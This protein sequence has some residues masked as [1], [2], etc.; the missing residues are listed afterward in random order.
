MGRRSGG[1]EIIA[2]HIPKAAGESFRAV[3]E[4]VYGEDDVE[5]DLNDQVPDDAG[6]LHR[7]F[8]AWN[9]ETR[10]A[11]ERRTSWR[12]VVT[13]HFP[14]WKYER[15]RGSAF[16]IVWLREPVAR[17]ISM[18]FYLRQKPRRD[19]GALAR[20][21]TPVERLMEVEWPSNPYTERFLR[22][23]DL[24][25]V[26]FVGIQEH[27]AEDVAD[28][29]GMLGWPPVDIPVSNRTTTPEYLSFR[30]SEELVRRIRAVNQ[31]DIELYE[32]ALELR[33]ARRLAAPAQ[34][35]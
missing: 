22:G 8:D 25:D 31:A 2:V 14:L 12:K 33:R 29:G 13:G 30:P 9:R 5:L 23:Y 32:R 24:E 19:G 7:D 35:R 34:A 26:D 21:A 11:V 16:T 3:L 28:L 20:G 6:S 17:L 18:Y 4:S 27:F 10:A 1:P 15:F